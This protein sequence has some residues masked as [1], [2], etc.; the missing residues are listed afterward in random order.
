MHEYEQ[1]GICGET[2]MHKNVCTC[3]IINA[4]TG[5]TPSFRSGLKRLSFLSSDAT[6]WAKGHMTV[7]A[8][9]EKKKKVNWGKVKLIQLKCVKFDETTCW[10]EQNLLGELC[11]TER[12]ELRW[13]PHVVWNKKVYL[14][15][16][17]KKSAWQEKTR[18]QNKWIKSQKQ[19]HETDGLTRAMNR[20]G[21]KETRAV[22]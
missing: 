15:K 21:S 10:A 1:K 14:R 16:G 19:G 17:T 11:M 8:A 5:F 7:A 18:R 12:C 6:G 20:R 3:K 22:W 4:V 2:I 13:D 9:V